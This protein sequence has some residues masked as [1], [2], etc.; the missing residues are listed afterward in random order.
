MNKPKV[1]TQSEVPQYG[2]GMILLMFAWPAAWYTFLIYV[3]WKQF[4]P[5]Y[6]TT[7]T[8]AQLA[9][10]VLGA[11]AELLAGLLLLRDAKATNFA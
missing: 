6:R 3:I 2:L 5:Q 8:W 10:I 11:G 9:I 1:F 7:P 4:V